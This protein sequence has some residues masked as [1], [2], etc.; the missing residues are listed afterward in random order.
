MENL[1]SSP[2]FPN[3]YD[4][5]ECDCNCHTPPKLNYN[6]KSHKSNKN[7][8]N[9]SQSQIISDKNYLTINNSRTTYCP[10]VSIS[11]C[12]NYK[13][14]YY[15][16][17]SELDIERK[18]NDRIK[19]DKK[20]NKDKLIKENTE[21]KKIISLKDGE[22]EEIGNEFE[23]IKDEFEKLNR[24][25]INVN[26]QLEN[27][28]GSNYNS[29]ELTAKY[30][31]LIKDNNENLMIIKQRENTINMLNNKLFQKEEEIKN[32]LSQLN[33]ACCDLKDFEEKYKSLLSINEEQ[34]ANNQNLL[35]SFN[36]LHNEN[37]IEENKALNDANNRLIIENENLRK[38]LTGIEFQYNELKK[39]Y[40]II[41][42]DYEQMKNNYENY[43][44]KNGELKGKNSNL[45]NSNNDLKDKCAFLENE[46]KKL[47]MN[48]EKYINENRELI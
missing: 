7:K 14:L 5:S 41:L 2:K 9:L 10:Y 25:Y 15:Q 1:F 31:L 44:K 3:N 32:L 47:K 26:Q 28:K 36:E 38:N 27:I 23:K 24:N 8:K 34:K 16:I 22:M 30:N 35:K 4:Y 13:D 20:M 45:Y 17:K 39:K 33:Q 43:I 6:L 29:N 40:N 48:N 46:N 37:I 12:D 21:L 19:Y 18:R 42:P 11:P